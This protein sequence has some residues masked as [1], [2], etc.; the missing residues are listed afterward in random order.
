MT[1]KTSRRPTRAQN[2]SG[3][4]K[5]VAKLVDIAV[6]KASGGAHAELLNAGPMALLY[7]KAVEAV[8]AAG[9]LAD[10]ALTL[11]GMQCLRAKTPVEVVDAFSVM[12]SELR[13]QVDLAAEQF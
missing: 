12:A 5:L 4:E 7:F 1:I 2:S 6:A 8:A 9:D 3:T 10:T 13:P 11:I